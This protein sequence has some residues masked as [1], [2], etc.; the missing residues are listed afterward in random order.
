M[1][2]EVPPFVIGAATTE[3]I[4]S[5]GWAEPGLYDY[6]PAYSGAR[7]PGQVAPFDPTPQEVVD[8]MLALAAVKNGDVVSELL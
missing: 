6:P 5:S 2:I 3:I 7:E 4:P 8:R 1:I